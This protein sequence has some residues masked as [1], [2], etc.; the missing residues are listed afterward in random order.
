MLLNRRKM[1]PSKSFH[2]MALCWL[3]GFMTFASC[4]LS[5]GAPTEKKQVRLTDIQGMSSEEK[6]AAYALQ[7]LLNRTKPQ[8][9]LR[10]G[11]D[12]RWMDF[13]L[14]KKG[15]WSDEGKQKITGLSLDGK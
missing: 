9:F 6:L 1:T 7:G 13:E 5:V 14:D 2:E 3:V 10:A 12:C 8:V 11:K 4:C 15:A